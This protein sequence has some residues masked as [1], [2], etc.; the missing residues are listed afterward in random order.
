[1]ALLGVLIEQKIVSAYYFVIGKG[2]TGAKVWNVVKQAIVE[3][4][5]AGARVLTIISDMGSENR[6]LWS[7]IG[8]YSIR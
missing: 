4:E 3:V 6:A 2:L 8:V 1:M 7:H 5:K